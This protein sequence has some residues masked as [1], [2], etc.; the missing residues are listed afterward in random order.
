MCDIILPTTDIH[1]RHLPELCLPYLSL[2]VLDDHTGLCAVGVVTGIETE[3]GTETGIGTETEIETGTG[4]VTVVETGGGGDLAHAAVAEEGVG[5]EAPE[6][7][8]AG[9]QAE[10]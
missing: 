9:P 2:F 5:A 8:E 10:I 1:F 3:I 4:T 6:D 7:G